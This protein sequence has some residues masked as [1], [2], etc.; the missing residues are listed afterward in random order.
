MKKILSL[1]V[2]IILVSGMQAQDKG[3]DFKLQKDGTFLTETGENYIIVNYD[4]LTAHEIY[5]KLCTN[6]GSVYNN[7][8]RVMS[9]VEDTSIKIRA[10]STR[11]VKGFGKV[12]RDAY[13]QFQI[14]IK[15]GR[16][17]VEA[18]TI[19]D[20]LLP[21]SYNDMANWWHKYPEKWMKNE[22]S[23]E[24][25]KLDIFY[26]EL[27]INAVIDGVLGYSPLK[28]DSKEEDNW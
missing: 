27:N 25:H 23:R 28:K 1:I 22:K 11:L 14:K 17:R 8:D 24:K 19:E 3:A 20:E 7:P 4:S 18:P 13:Y 16:V 9:N 5:Q 10:I 15:D 12:Y 21:I 26:V 6:A 2:A